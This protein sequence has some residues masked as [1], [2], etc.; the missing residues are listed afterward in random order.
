ML[1]PFGPRAVVA[2]VGFGA[3]SVN[4]ATIAHGPSFC[5]S[6]DANV[7]NWEAGR[8]LFPRCRGNP[9]AGRERLYVRRQFAGEHDR[10]WWPVGWSAAEGARWVVWRVDVLTGTAGTDVRF[11]AMALAVP[12]S[13]FPGSRGAGAAGSGPGLMEALVRAASTGQ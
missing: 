4:N 1:G 6:R 12:W 10:E 13:W 11:Q 3:A 5:S 7:Q 8:T 9:S 2:A